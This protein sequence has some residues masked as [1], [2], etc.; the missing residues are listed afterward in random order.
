[1]RNDFLGN[2]SPD[3]SGYVL[4]HED[5]I[6]ATRQSTA[7]KD[8]WLESTGWNICHV[9]ERTFGKAGKP[10]AFLFSDQAIPRD[11]S[12]PQSNNNACSLTTP[13][14]ANLQVTETKTL[15][16][17]LGVVKDFWC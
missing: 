12:C 6:L 7:I 2:I 13:G 11:H 15:P 14:H 4:G 9:I 16:F 17:S 8:N 3:S 1:M 5:V 10:E